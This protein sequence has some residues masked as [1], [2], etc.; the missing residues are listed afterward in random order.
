MPNKCSHQDHS[1]MRTCVVCKK[2]VDQNRLLNFFTID[3]EI[4]F[5]MQRVLPLRK[6][7]ICPNA[8]CFAGLAKWRK[9]YQKR[10]S[11]KK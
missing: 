10:N 6:L 1:P 7:Y 5:D 11:G 8:D 2:K 9:R 3:N 4:V